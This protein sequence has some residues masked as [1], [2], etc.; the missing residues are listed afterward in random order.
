MRT[1]ERNVGH[2]VSAF[3]SISDRNCM[4][5]VGEGGEELG[6]QTQGNALVGKRMKTPDV[7][8]SVPTM[9]DVLRSLLQSAPS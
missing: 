3:A 7:R 5:P 6:R 8:T 1:L 4:M 2:K 9:Y